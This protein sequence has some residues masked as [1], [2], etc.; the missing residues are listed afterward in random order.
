MERASSRGVVR[1]ES[2]RRTG[3]NRSQ[4]QLSLRLHNTPE[5]GEVGQSTRV[6]KQCRK[7]PYR[8]DCC[9]SQHGPRCY[10]LCGEFIVKRNK[11]TS[12]RHCKVLDS[13][14]GFEDWER[15]I[16]EPVLFQNRNQVL[17]YDFGEGRSARQD[18]L[19]VVAFG[20]QLLRSVVTDCVNSGDGTLHQ[21]SG[22]LFNVRILLEQFGNGVSKERGRFYGAVASLAGN[23]VD[24]ESRSWLVSLRRKVDS[25]V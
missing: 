18:L 17:R 21:I 1:R 20:D 16:E 9:Q 25:E 19:E 4:E 8:E 2:C 3:G 6:V 15:N 12:L 13:R 11:P 14:A 24:L 7:R 10:G 22:K 5:R 23:R